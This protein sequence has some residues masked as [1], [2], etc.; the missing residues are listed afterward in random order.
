MQNTF[1]MIDV[2][3]KAVTYRLAVA[4]GEIETQPMKN[5]LYESV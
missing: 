1:K 5:R 4:C 3:A 2:G